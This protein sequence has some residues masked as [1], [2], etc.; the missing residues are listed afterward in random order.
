MSTRAG[1]AERFC[2]FFLRERRL[3]DD[4]RKKA[5]G[6]FVVPGTTDAIRFPG[7][8]TAPGYLIWNCRCTTRAVIAGWQSMSKQGQV[9]KTGQTYAEWKADH[10]VSQDILT[11]KKKGEAIRQ[12]YINEYRGN[13]GK[14]VDNFSVKEYTDLVESYLN[15]DPELVLKHAKSGRVHKGIYKDALTKKKSRLEQSIKS[16][17]KQVE[18]HTNKIANPSEKDTGWASKNENAQK[19]LIRKWKTDRMRNAQQVY[20]EIKVWEERFSE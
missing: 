10:G 3:T 17:A 2:R 12:K 19:G 4:P 13:G 15:K 11:Q 20:I 6:V 1:R 7:D 8:P 18:E 5:G 16:H 14:R 9:I